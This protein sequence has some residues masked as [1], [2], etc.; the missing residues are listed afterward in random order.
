MGSDSFHVPAWQAQES[1]QPRLYHDFASWW[2]LL[3]SPDDY[4]EEAEFYRHTFDRFCTPEPRSLLELGAG[5]GNNA[6]HLKAH[7]EMTLVDLSEDMLAVSRELNPECR[8]VAGDMRSLRLDRKFDGVFIHDAIVYMTTPD[9]L[10]QAVETAH[11]HCRAGGA[12]LIVPDHTSETFVSTTGHGGEDGEERSLRYIQ[13]EWDPDP[14]DNTYLTDFV[15]LLREK[16]NALRVEFDR[17]LCGLFG[18]ETWMRVMREVGFEARALPFEHS[19]VATGACEVFV[20]V[21]PGT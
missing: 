20:G 11:V 7:F 15:Y 17:H 9:D 19:E 14:G 12:V 18:R 4:V 5:G 1:P 8:H 13:W 2:P 10:R 21:K 6:F 16:D 3:S